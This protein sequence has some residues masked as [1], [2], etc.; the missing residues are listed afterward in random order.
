MRLS[1]Y[2]V[3]HRFTSGCQGIYY[4]TGLHQVFMVFSTSQVYMRVI[5]VFS[6]SQVYIRL[7]WYL[8]RNRFISGCHGIKYVTGL[9]QVGMGFSTSQVYIRL[10]WYLVHNRFASGCH[11]I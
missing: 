7:S 5:M 3:R 8:L 11:G 9:H 4:V 6:T 1:W 10:S 2:L